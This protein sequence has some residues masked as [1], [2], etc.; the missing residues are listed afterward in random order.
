MNT[1][2]MGAGIVVASALAA[3][4]DAATIA[5]EPSETIGGD[6]D[7]VVLSLVIHGIGGGSPSLGDFDVDVGYDPSALELVS[8]EYGP[9]L[10]DPLL[11]EALDFG[12]GEVS[13]GR[14]DMA[15]V[16]LLEPATLV[17]TEPSSF[18]LAYLTFAIHG[19]APGDQT[20]VWVIDPIVD[21]TFAFGD[22]FG[23]SLDVTA[24]GEASI[25]RPGDA[26]AEPR[27]LSFVPILL[28]SVAIAAHLRR[29]R[30]P[31]PPRPHAE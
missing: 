5:F 25:R 22:E 23:N 18:A 17:G 11:G 10:G 1:R 4:L 29:N 6:G 8:Y 13:P 2:W 3:N 12:L 27:E 21:F 15:L 20:I 30:A 16:S 24:I 28:L 19:L 7:L 26:V 9:F 31:F 14:I